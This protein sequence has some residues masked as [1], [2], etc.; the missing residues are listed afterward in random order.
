MSVQLLVLNIL[1]NYH[2]QNMVSAKG[3][4]RR[5]VFRSSTNIH[6]IFKTFKGDMSFGQTVVLMMTEQKYK[7]YKAIY[8]V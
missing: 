6:L 3:L 4:S 2:E 1:Y 7:Y 8:F 5:A